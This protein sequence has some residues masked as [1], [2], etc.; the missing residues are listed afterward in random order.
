[1]QPGLHLNW[2]WQKREDFQD[3]QMSKRR[4]IMKAV[5]LVH[6]DHS[7]VNRPFPDVQN[8]LSAAPASL[9]TCLNLGFVAG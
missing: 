9:L 5:S 2:Q 8:S 3:E 1:M 7:L 6:P 4:P